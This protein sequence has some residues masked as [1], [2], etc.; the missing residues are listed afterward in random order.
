MV[1][2]TGAIER[3]FYVSLVWLTNLDTR[4]SES[5]SVRKKINL[6]CPTRKDP[7][8]VRHT[9]VSLLLA[10]VAAV[11]AGPSRSLPPADGSLTRHRMSWP[12]DIRHDPLIRRHEPPGEVTI[13]RVL[14]AAVSVC[15]G[16]GS[17]AWPDKS[18]G[19]AITNDFVDLRISMFLRNVL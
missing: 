3:A 7:R 15:L 18:G 13:R 14:E 4:S 16:T 10:A 6:R 9:L 2:S 5:G 11:L 17:S 19:I 8:G 12:L 1:S